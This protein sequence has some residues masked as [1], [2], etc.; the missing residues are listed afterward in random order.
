MAKHGH[1]SL[2]LLTL[3]NVEMCRWL[4]RVARDSCRRKEV[5][6]MTKGADIP[7]KNGPSSSVSAPS[8]HLNVERPKLLEAGSEFKSFKL[9][10]AFI[11]IK[12]MYLEG[13][14][15]TLTGH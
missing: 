6:V 5:V 15:K 9:I 10:I 14:R 11:P 12:H 8:L 7:N 13:L 4:T 3:K 1:F 2:N